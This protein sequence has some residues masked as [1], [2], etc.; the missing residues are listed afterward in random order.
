[1]H[2]VIFF[3]SSY[4]FLSTNHERVNSLIWTTGLTSQFYPVHS[5]ECIRE[6]TLQPSSLH[7]R[8]VNSLMQSIDNWIDKKTV[9][10]LKLRSQFTKKPISIVNSVKN[11]FRT[12]FVLS[13]FG[14]GLV[15][16]GF[17]DQHLGQISRV[18]EQLCCL[19]NLI[20]PQ[21]HS[22]LPKLH[23]PTENWLNSRCLTTV[24]VQDWVFT[25]W[26]YL[27]TSNPFYIIPYSSASYK[28][29]Q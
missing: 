5:I 24:I 29:K 4:L 8:R 12:Q 20:A 13:T 6:S 25:T 23:Y 7:G 19:Y 2:T 27:L 10:P 1:M 14:K 3:S 18:L 22:P 15:G 28:I 26:H 21:Q 16:K 11:T 17:W 9:N